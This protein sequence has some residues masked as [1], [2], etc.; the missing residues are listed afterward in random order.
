MSAVLLSRGV[1]RNRIHREPWPRNQKIL[2]RIKVKAA[3]TE[4]DN[5]NSL[6][7]KTL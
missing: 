5:H 6:A 1:T 7:R 3:P 4:I 2:R